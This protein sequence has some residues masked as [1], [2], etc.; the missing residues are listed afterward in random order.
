M[1]YLTPHQHGAEDHLQ[2][3]EEVVTNED[4]G[5]TT[6][7]P[8]LTGADGLDAGSGCWGGGAREGRREGGGT[9]GRGG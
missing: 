3:V 2:A 5:G 6:R 9:G 4:D 1:C 7:G 8:A